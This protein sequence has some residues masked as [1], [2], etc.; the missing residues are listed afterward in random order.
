MRYF[1]DIVDIKV[2]ALSFRK[3]FKLFTNKFTK[4]R[5]ENFSSR[6]YLVFYFNQV[7]L[8]FQRGFNFMQNEDKCKNLIRVF[9]D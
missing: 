3:M 1:N 8:Y 2:K 7:K 5:H 4:L 6:L 9:Y